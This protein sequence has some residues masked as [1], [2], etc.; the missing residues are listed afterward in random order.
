MFPWFG[1]T[2][3]KRT[4]ERTKASIFQQ[5]QRESVLDVQYKIKEAYF[6]LY[7][8]ERSQSILRNK[9]EY[10]QA[11]ERIANNRVEA[12]KA[13]LADVLRIQVL[14]EAL[15]NDVIKME[16][17]KEKPIA[18]LKL[19]TNS[20]NVLPVFDMDSLSLNTMEYDEGKYLSQAL[21]NHPSLEK[22]K[23]Q[24]EISRQAISLTQL[25]SKPSLGAGLDYILVN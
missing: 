21:E 18:T 9:T 3:N 8:L 17:D 4:L 12:G 22:Y 14:L 5:Q 7:E 16:N 1:I 19:L 6:K 25:N 11:L 23:I 2:D 15:N 20:P 24:K 10:L 13:S